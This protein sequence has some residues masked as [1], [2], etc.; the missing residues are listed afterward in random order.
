MSLDTKKQEKTTRKML[1]AKENINSYLIKLKRVV[2]V[3]KNFG[4][5]DILKSPRKTNYWI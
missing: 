2:S 5:S 3:C 4:N 1:P